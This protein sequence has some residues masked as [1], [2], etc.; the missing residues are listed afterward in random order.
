MESDVY[1]IENLLEKYDMELDEVVRKIK[2]SKAKLV[3][4]QFPDGLKIYATAIVD[5]LRERTKAEFLVF[6][7]SCFGACDYPVGFEHLK[8][9]IDLV[10]QFGHSDLMPT[11]M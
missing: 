2:V 3:L 5:F 6:L 1:T 8:P 11:Y 9:K 7:G 10:V 4:I